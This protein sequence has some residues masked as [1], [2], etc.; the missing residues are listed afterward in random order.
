MR[1]EKNRLKKINDFY[2]EKFEHPLKW[3]ILTAVLV[4]GM[5]MTAYSRLTEK[6][7]G[8]S[9]DPARTEADTDSIDYEQLNKYIED[10][11]IV[12]GTNDD[13]D[14]ALDWLNVNKTLYSSTL[15]RSEKFLY[16][17]LV[18]STRG[19]FTEDAAQYAV[20]NCDYD[21]SDSALYWANAFTA[22]GYDE[23]DIKTELGLMERLGGGFAQKDIDYAAENI[24]ELYKNSDQYYQIDAVVQDKLTSGTDTDV[25]RC[26]ETADK[27]LDSIGYSE[28]EVT[29]ALCTYC[30]YDRATVEEALEKLNIDWGL[31]ALKTASRFSESKAGSQIIEEILRNIHKYPGG[32]SKWA[33]SKIGK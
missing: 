5:A 32:E 23:S 2:D 20:E 1:E 9:N 8:T 12:T 26:R 31:Q 15:H 28:K 11:D 19:G 3:K 21:F 16:L 33:I 22:V 13:R 27:W 4:F 18:S 29:Y 7:A 6:P 30:N 17:D 25:D 14:A 24:T 10:M